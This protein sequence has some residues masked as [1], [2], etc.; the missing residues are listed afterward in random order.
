MINAAGIGLLEENKI[1]DV[2]E[3]ENEEIKPEYW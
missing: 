2:D 1:P 3:E